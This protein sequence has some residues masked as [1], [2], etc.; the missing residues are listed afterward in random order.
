M[1]A[2]LTP[3]A[4]ACPALDAPTGTASQS[5]YQ[6]TYRV[7]PAEIRVG[8]PFAIDVSVCA[9]G[10]PFGGALKVDADMPAHRHA[11]N[12]WPDVHSEGPG[13]FRVEGLLFHMRGAWRLR[14][15]LTTAGRPV[16]LDIPQIVE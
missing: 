16:R 13:R 1:L 3:P 2:L 11:M 6:L 7:D 4:A 14:F 15:E 5:G 9:A 8:A 12:Y 10:E